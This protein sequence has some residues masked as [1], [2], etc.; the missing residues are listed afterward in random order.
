MDSY[1]ISPINR[2]SAFGAISAAGLAVASG[3]AFAQKSYPNK[4]I[5]IVVPFT[6]GSA[7]DALSRFFGEKLGSLLNQSF[8][9]ENRPGGNGLITIQ[10]VKGAPADGYSILLGNISLMAINPVVLKDLGYD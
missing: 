8:I 1:S 4:T 3:R 6:P 10:A 5:R 7:S 2:R 9:T